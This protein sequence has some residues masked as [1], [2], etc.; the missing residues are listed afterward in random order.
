MKEAYQSEVCQ[1]GCCDY[2]KADW[3]DASKCKTC[4]FWEILSET[5]GVQDDN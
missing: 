5:G 3:C 2:E 1:E 4:G